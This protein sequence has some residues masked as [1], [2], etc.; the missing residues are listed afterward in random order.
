MTAVVDVI[1]MCDHWYRIVVM[2]ARPVEEL[3]RRSTCRDR[4]R[5]VYTLPPSEL[6]AWTGLGYCA[7]MYTVF[8]S[9]IPAS[10][11]F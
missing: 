9:A 7:G 3:R 5:P 1:Q 10:T 8:A 11:L 2:L 4:G 6:K